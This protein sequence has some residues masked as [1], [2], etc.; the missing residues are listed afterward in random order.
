MRHW[1][2]RATLFK[3]TNLIGQLNLLR[4]TLIVFF[5][6]ELITFI[7]PHS[8]RLYEKKT[9]EVLMANP[10]DQSSE[11]AVRAALT[12]QSLLQKYDR[13]DLQELLSLTSC[14]WLLS[15][16]EHS[17]PVDAPPGIIRQMRNILAPNIIFL[18]PFDSNLPLDY[19]MVHQIVRE[20]TVG[21]YGFNQLPVVSLVPNY[22]QSSTCQLPPAYY[23][24]KVG[25]ILINIDYTSKALWHGSYIS[26]EKRTRFSELWRSIMAVDSDGVPQT[27]KDVLTEFLNAGETRSLSISNRQRK[28]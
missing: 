13:K 11:K 27:K 18:A 16:D 24:T 10:S 1:L 6:R 26:R 14:N 8:Y 12:A 7:L 3:L 4:G 17:L 19:R 20:L 28:M 9:D 5:E 21:I 23:D 15:A 2:L 22:D 25:Q